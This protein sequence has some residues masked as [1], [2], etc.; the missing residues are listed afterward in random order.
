MTHAKIHRAKEISYQHQHLH[1]RMAL[2]HNRSCIAVQIHAFLLS[3]R[4]RSGRDEHYDIRCVYYC[5]AARQQQSSYK[6]YILQQHQQRTNDRERVNTHTHKKRTNRKRKIIVHSQLTSL[7]EIVSHFAA[8]FAIFMFLPVVFDC[9]CCCPSSL[10]VVTAITIALQRGRG[11]PRFLAIPSCRLPL[12]LFDVRWPKIWKC[13]GNMRTRRCMHICVAAV[14][15]L[16]TH[17]IAHAIKMMGETMRVA[18]LQWEL[19]TLH[20]RV[21]RNC[22][23]DVWGWLPNAPFFSRVQRA[24]RK[25]LHIVAPNSAR[26]GGGY[27]GEI[28]PEFGNRARKAAEYY[29]RQ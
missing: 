6:T 18:C 1:Q 27:T 29:T 20:G 14:L 8:S 3:V 23:N 12:L 7:P 17:K 25:P 24:L 2:W 16:V 10:S 9:C 26:G 4:F 15:L 22:E 5:T 11:P 28:A 21:S 19:C 13:L